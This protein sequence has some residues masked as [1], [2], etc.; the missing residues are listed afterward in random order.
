MVT[1]ERKL[2]RKQVI[3]REAEVRGG[4]SAV[5]AESPAAGEGKLQA[6]EARP[7]E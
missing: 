5:A 3:P 1:V 2:A 7:P 6:D 4:R